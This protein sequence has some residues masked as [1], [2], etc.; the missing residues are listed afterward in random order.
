M[1]IEFENRYVVVKRADIDRYLNDEGKTAFCKC[2][3]TIS[4]ARSVEGKPSNTYLVINSDEPITVTTPNAAYG[5]AEI[6]ARNLVAWDTSK[7][8]KLGLLPEVYLANK[9]LYKELTGE[10]Y[11]FRRTCEKFCIGDDWS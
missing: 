5:I 2:L 10:E 11:E 9:H 8:K 6:I 1:S 3:E 4:D 7:D